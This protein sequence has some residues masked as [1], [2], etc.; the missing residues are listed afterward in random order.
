MDRFAEKQSQIDRRRVET[1][2]SY[3]ALWSNMIA[4]WN[5][6]EAQDR[7]WLM[8]AANYLFRTN[9]IRWAID[10]LTLNWRLKDVPSVN[11]LRDLAGLSF[12]LLTHS[13]DD[14]LDLDLL[15]VLRRL[16]ITWIIPEFLLTDVVERSG[17]PMERIIVPSSLVPLDCDGV[18][19]LP[20]DG[21]HWET[22]PQGTRRGVPA[23]GYLVECNGKRWLFP[24]D[25]R[26]YDL[27]QLPRTGKVDVAFAHIWLGRNSALADTPPL[28]DAFC[29]FC[30]NL[31][32]GRIVLTHLNEFGRDANDLW[33]D[34]HA[35]LVRS[36]ICESS[37]DLP[38]THLL[39]G[40]S[41][42]L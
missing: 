4:E 20:F 25:T 17:L 30:L 35:L 16:S 12:V 33:D 24:G 32:A 19:I 34:T 9:N 31:D 29:Q 2:A 1:C 6:S 3:P 40:S 26:S 41:V 10:P 18:R 5:L 27:T 14:H 36:K 11:A 13:H 38:V 28:L 23:M 42:E 7:V 22:D 37:P 15:N 39:M 21:F 8:Y